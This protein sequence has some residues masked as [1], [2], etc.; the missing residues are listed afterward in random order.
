MPVLASNC[1]PGLTKSQRFYQ[2][3]LAVGGTD[4]GCY[5]GL[6]FIE[7]LR[8]IL[9]LLGSEECIY[10]EWDFFA[11]WLELLSPGVC[12]GYP[13]DELMQK[14]YAVLYAE[15][16]DPDLLSPEC[17]LG[18]PPEQQESFL[19]EIVEIVPGGEFIYFRPDGF[20]RYFRPDGTS[21][22]LRT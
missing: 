11:A 14:V 19:V 12:T 4:D 10:T 8:L 20:S 18:V 17:F 13:L 21:L 1:L 15:A 16:A 5:L 7:Q 22:Y 9:A 2:L 3:Y 6:T